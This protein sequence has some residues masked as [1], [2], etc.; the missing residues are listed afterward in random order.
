M[1]IVQFVGVEAEKDVIL[2]LIKNIKVWVASVDDLEVGVENVTPVYIPSM[3]ECQG[4]N[5]IFYVQ[6]LFKVSFTGKVRTPLIC[7]KLS[8]A[9]K[10]G[11]NEFIAIDML[12]VVPKSATVIIRLVEREHEYLRWNIVRD[13]ENNDCPGCGSA[14]QMMSGVCP[15]CG[16]KLW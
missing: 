4:E 9:I 3:Q 1:P 2:D 12:N 16:K 11:F 14:H 5:V 15:D 13:D 8:K 7:K 10:K 6:E